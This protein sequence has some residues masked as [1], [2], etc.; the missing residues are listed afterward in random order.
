M[1]KS[2]RPRAPEAPPPPLARTETTEVHVALTVDASG[3]MQ[4]VATAVIRMIRDFIFEQR[5]S[6]MTADLALT[7]FS[8]TITPVFSGPIHRAP[9]AFEYKAFG[10][11]ALLDALG[12]AITKARAA[13][14]KRTTIAIITDGEECSSREWSANTIRPAI[15]QAV[16][17]EWQ[18]LFLATQPSAIAK[19]KSWGIPESCCSVH[20]GNA[21]TY[22]NMARVL[23]G[24]VEAH[25]AGKRIGF[26]PGQRR[27]L[28]HWA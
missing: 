13:A 23:S 2:I 19:A 20:G 17:D 11:T 27:L 24:A 5:R 1:D 25:A 4:P 12:S 16:R 18:I 7:F 10:G 21:G 15:E 3:S 6:L 26:T 14:R 8:N 22:S 9:M 28:E